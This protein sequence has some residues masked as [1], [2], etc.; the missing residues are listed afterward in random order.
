MEQFISYGHDLKGL[1]ARASIP[2]DTSSPLSVKSGPADD[3][4]KA[5]INENIGVGA[6]GARYRPGLVLQPNL[7]VAPVWSGT[8]ARQPLFDAIHE[9]A[10]SVKLDFDIVSTA[11]NVFEFQTYYPQIGTNRTIGNPANLQPVIFS[12]QR[13][14]MAIPVISINHGAEINAIYILGQGEAAAR[15]IVEVTDALAIAQSPW[16]RVEAVRQYSNVAQGA[17]TELTLCGVKEIQANMATT[18]GSFEAIQT[19]AST[20]GVHYF[21]GDVVTGLYH[22]TLNKR[23][24]GATF[25][26]SGDNPQE[27]IKLELSD[28]T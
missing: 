17:L 4:I 16:N 28:V 3:V 14:N 22:I 19:P 11:P 25:A 12:L 9:I 18:S 6:G 20:Y 23:L 8:Q 27:V 2:A 7:S 13:N 24:I 10:L 26:V 1:I 15:D 21:D 5:Y